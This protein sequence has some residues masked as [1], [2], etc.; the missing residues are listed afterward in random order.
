MID[1]LLSELAV[2]VSIE[3][4]VSVFLEAFFRLATNG[5]EGHIKLYL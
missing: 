3:I 2:F 4:E 5:L 1:F